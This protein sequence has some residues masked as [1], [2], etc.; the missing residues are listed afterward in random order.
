MCMERYFETPKEQSKRMDEF[1]F[2]E[3]DTIR[4]EIKIQSAQEIYK[5]DDYKK[6]I[7]DNEYNQYQIKENACI[8]KLVNFEYN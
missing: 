8:D 4:S 5:N 1:I 3:K 6:I 7:K 2:Q